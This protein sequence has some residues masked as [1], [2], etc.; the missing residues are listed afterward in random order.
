MES[1]SSMMSHEFR[2]PLATGLMF[3]TSI[4]GMLADDHPAKELIFLVQGSLNLLLSLVNDILDL[5][6]IKAGKLVTQMQKFQP[7]ECFDFV[8]KLMQIQADG[9]RI[10]FGFWMV[11]AHQLDRMDSVKFFDQMS[12]LALPK[13]LYGDELR[14]KQI[15]INLVKNALK[16]T[17]SGFVRILC[18]YDAFRR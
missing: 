15:L 13:F 3:L 9:K 11:P 8:I 16:F 2:T 12:E 1:Y 4:L 6:L 7:Q 5:K 10:D 14:L 18:G 17:Q